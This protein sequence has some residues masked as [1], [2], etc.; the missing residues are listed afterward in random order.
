M[1]AQYKGMCWLK[2]DLQMQTPADARH[3]QGDRLEA[4]Q[5]A[6]AATAF[7]EACY[8]AEL[9]I[10]GITDHNF[11][12]KEF[13]PHL[14]SA[15]AELE[16]EHNHS[17]SLFPGFEFEAAGVGRGVHIL[18]LFE[19]GADLAQLDAIQSVV[20]RT[21]ELEQTANWQSPIRISKTYCASFK[22]SMVAS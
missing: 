8:H 20:L 1:S 14:Q 7:A 9:D 16:R 11:L 18:C 6:S 4:G 12:S 2:C 10:I 19:P 5:E 21:R 15:F 22:K 13:I 3:W 17:V